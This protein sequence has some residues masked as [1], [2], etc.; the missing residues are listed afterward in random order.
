MWKI[1]METQR[2]FYI[3]GIPIL[4]GIRRRKGKRK[5]EDSTMYNLG[6]AY[7]IK[8]R[9]QEKIWVK[10]VL[11]EELKR[12]IGISCR[13]LYAGKNAEV[14][15]A[16]LLAKE[17]KKCSLSFFFIMCGGKRFVFLKENLIFPFYS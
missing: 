1:I 5:W 13:L 6:F 14:Y 17:L 2:Y 16:F 8:T 11:E 15:N 3:P 10:G 4:C 9:K 7:I 12:R